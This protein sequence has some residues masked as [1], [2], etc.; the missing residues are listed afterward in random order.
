MRLF[1]ALPIPEPVKQAALRWQEELRQIAPGT[2]IRWAT[3]DQLHLTLK[4][5][6]EVEAVRVEPLLAATRAACQGHGPFNLEAGRAGFFPNERNPRVLWAGLRCES[7]ALQS[8]QGSVEARLAEFAEKQEDRP[9]SPHLTLA[10]IKRVS[11]TETRALTGKVGSLRDRSLG[12]WRA[13]YVRVMQSELHPAGSRHTCLAEV[14]L[15]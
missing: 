15:S 11:P 2:G 10:R 7:G 3:A 1:V 8:L 5:L 9:F 14:E 13:N 12:E 4:F 6:G